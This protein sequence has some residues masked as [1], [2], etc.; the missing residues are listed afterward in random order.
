MINHNFLSKNK[1]PFLHPIN[2]II[3]NHLKLP[4]CFTFKTPKTGVVFQTKTTNNETPTSTKK[5]NASALKKRGNPSAA[6]LEWVG[7]DRARNFIVPRWKPE[8]VVSGG[9]WVEGEMVEISAKK[10]RW[11]ILKHQLLTGCYYM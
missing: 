4:S 6:D 11:E 5:R 2:K 3:G 9:L 1:K 10:N 8:S 7:L